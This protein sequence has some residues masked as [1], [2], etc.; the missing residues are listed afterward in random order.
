MKAPLNRFIVLRRMTPPPPPI[1]L[2]VMLPHSLSILI[3]WFGVD[4]RLR[5]ILALLPASHVRAGWC[6]AF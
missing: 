6:L 3:L 5:T 4:L 1:H 2:V